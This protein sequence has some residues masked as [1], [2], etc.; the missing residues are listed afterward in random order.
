MVASR[1]TD[2]AKV[3]SARYE[4]QRAMAR[5]K[6]S[7]SG[8]EGRDVASSSAAKSGGVTSD[9]NQGTDLGLHDQISG[10]SCDIEEM[11]D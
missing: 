4:F 11:I 3:P 2:N 8:P 5:S 7:V 1:G 9:T 6:C 10:L